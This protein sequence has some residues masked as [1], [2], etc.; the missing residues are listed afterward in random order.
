VSRSPDVMTP[1]S[2]ASVFEI[3]YPP[4]FQSALRHAR[5]DPQESVPSISRTEPAAKLER[6]LML[7][8]A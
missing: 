5:H 3:E 2:I 4:P 7:D 8:A 1:S 6:A